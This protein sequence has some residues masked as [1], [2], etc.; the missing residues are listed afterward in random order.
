MSKTICSHRRLKPEL[1]K[2]I[3]EEASRF[4]GKA[5][6]HNSIKEVC[7]IIEKKSGVSVHSMA[8]HRLLVGHKNGIGDDTRKP[9]C[10]R[11]SVRSPLCVM[12]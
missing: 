2:L 12:F 5:L 10:K 8:V 1:K 9:K 6:A 4:N 7:R 3:L 11:R